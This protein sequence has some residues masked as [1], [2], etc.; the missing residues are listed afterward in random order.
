VV[1]AGIFKAMEVAAGV[2]LPADVNLALQLEAS[3]S[4]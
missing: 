4:A 3:P 1:P 2:A